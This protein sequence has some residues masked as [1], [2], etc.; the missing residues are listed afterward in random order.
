MDTTNLI[1]KE[2]VLPLS[3]TYLDKKFKT[4]TALLDILLKKDYKKMTDSRYMVNVLVDADDAENG[5]EGFDTKTVKKTT[6]KSRSLK[7]CTSIITKKITIS[8]TANTIDKSAK[9]SIKEKSLR[10]IGE[11]IEAELLG[12]QKM[13]DNGVDRQMG[14]LKSFVPEAHKVEKNIS[15]ILKADKKV[16]EYWLSDILENAN[17]EE[18]THAFCGNKS[19]KYLDKISNVCASNDVTSVNLTTNRITTNN[20]EIEPLKARSLGELEILLVDINAID[21]G[22]LTPIQE[23][24]L[25]KTMDG[26]ESLLVWEG[27]VLPQI[28]NALFLI[29]LVDDTAA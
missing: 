1:T 2:G 5:V 9:N 27:S 4:N 12:N 20:G 23:E 25:G 26:E 10:K 6:I 18:F 19:K 14:G 17:Y 8:R 22:Q 3:A 11:K 28:D 16:D 7:N 15:E 21:F 13:K 24:K 29:T